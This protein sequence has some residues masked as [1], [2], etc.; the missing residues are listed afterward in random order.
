MAQTIRLW[1][2]VWSPHTKTPSTLVAQ[3]ASAATVP[4][5]ST[6]DAELV[7]HVAALRAHEAHGQQHQV[8]TGSSNSE[9]GTSSKTG[10]PSSVRISTVWPRR[11]RTAPDPSST[12]S[13]VV[14]AKSRSP[15]SSW[16]EDVRRMSGQSGPRI[17]GQAV[18]RGLGHD[19]ELV[20][21]G[22][23]LAVRGAQAVGPGVAAADDDHVLALGGDG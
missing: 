21:R 4:R 12:N 18:A 3:S 19:L 1:P 22:R 10:R 5:G 2:R 23:A 15:P 20:H 17:V 16:A 7:H 9:P 6:L 14:T 13:V 11:A 8:G